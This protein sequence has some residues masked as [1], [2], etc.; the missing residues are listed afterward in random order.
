MIGVCGLL[1]GAAVLPVCFGIGFVWMC[2]VLGFGVFGCFHEI[3]ACW[4]PV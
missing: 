4:F 1:I 2:Y 3:V